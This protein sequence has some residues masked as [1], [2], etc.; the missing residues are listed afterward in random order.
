VATL[1]FAVLAFCFITATAPFVLACLPKV[2]DEAQTLR[3][4]ICFLI[5]ATSCVAMQRATEMHQ[6]ERVSI[7]LPLSGSLN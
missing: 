4:G 7:L 6:L 5:D 1:F 2:L 3:C